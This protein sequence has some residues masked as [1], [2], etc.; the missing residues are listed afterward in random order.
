MASMPPRL[1]RHGFGWLVL[2]V[3]M[4]GL[5]S[6]ADAQSAK[7]LTPN[8]EKVRFRLADRNLQIELVTSE[9]YL[10]SPI[11]VA[12]NEDGRM[13]V[14][15]ITDYPNGRPSGRVV[16]FDD[17]GGDGTYDRFTVFAE[18]LS[19]PTSVLPY[20]DGVLVMTSREIVY[21][22]DADND[23]IS[24]KREVILTGLEGGHPLLRAGS[25]QW[26]LDNWIYASHGGRGELRRPQDP[27]S[28]AVSVEGRDFRFLPDGSRVEVLTG[29][30]PAGLAMNPYGARFPSSNAAPIQ[31]VVLEE[32]YFTRNP[33]LPST[34]SVIEIL[35]GQDSTRLAFAGS[36]HERE[37]LRAVRGIHFYRG[38]DLPNRYLNNLF[39]AE[40]RLNLIHRR[41]VEQQGGTF[42]A[43]RVDEEAEFLTSLD[44]WFR[45]VSIESGPD[46]ALYIVDFYRDGY[47][48]PELEGTRARS[49]PEFSRG[50]D[51]GRLWRVRPVDRVGAS[52]PRITM[53]PRLSDATNVELTRLLGHENGW[54]RETAQRLLVERNAQ[55]AVPA[56]RSIFT[57][58]RS[59][60]ARLHALWTLEGLGALDDRTLITALS[61]VYPGLRSSALR[62]AEPRLAK[63]PE[64]RTAVLRTVVDRD[65]RV[66]LE[67]AATL[68]ELSGDDVTTVLLVIANENAGDPWVRRTLFGAIARDPAGF[69]DKLLT[70]SPQLM[71]APTVDQFQI[72]QQAAQLIGGRNQPAE[73]TKTLKRIA[74]S[75]NGPL[76]R[77]QRALLT[78]LADGLAQADRPLRTLRS[79]LG[80]LGANV[81]HVDKLFA[82]ARE[83]AAAPAADIEQRLA[84]I[85]LLAEDI[86]AQSGAT[87]MALATSPQS[88]AVQM[89]AVRAIITAGD[90]QQIESLL[91]DWSRLSTAARR[92]AVANL[93]SE[94]G[95]RD[96]LVA[97]LES[98]RIPTS[99]VEPGAVDALRQLPDPAERSRVTKL[100]APSESV[101]RKALAEK[102]QRE[103]ASIVSPAADAGQ[104]PEG[105]ST[106]SD[107]R[108]A[109]LFS[110]HCLACH[111]IAGHGSAFGLD[112]AL[113]SSLPRETL[114]SKILDPSRDLL[115]SQ[116][117]AVVVT[118]AGRVLYGSV[119][120]ESSQAVTLRRP[121]GEELTLPRSL[122]ATLH[123]TGR[124]LMPEGFEAILTPADVADL[125][126]F[127]QQP[128]LELLPG[129]V[130]VMVE[131]PGFKPIEQR[132]APDLAPLLPPPPAAP[133]TP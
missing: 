70:Y 35:D 71:T 81:A 13:F 76:L 72:L 95:A 87:L 92:A 123:K 23:G 77:G 101:D 8:E 24:E 9:P 66:R 73:L 129:A 96:L 49:K 54:W 91:A 131:E 38:D 80:G 105:S 65:P 85:R 93:L 108:G 97:A 110:Q 63:S 37:Q 41:R 128:Q 57:E 104:E 48:F 18:N 116:S 120:H 2:A 6:L 25:L 62:L 78:G 51:R 19:L 10:T 75:G 84:A 90:R 113:A 46:G 94:P 31:H 103:L 55:D 114:V 43:R 11:D 89:A 50:I 58:Q 15:E 34:P 133:F 42:V 86:P 107:V 67:L 126:A 122:I 28:K 22:I 115:S 5:T 17:I 99:D 125:L 36:S 16:A 44:P 68:G 88:P 12:W 27:A 40:P 118:T 26:G 132:K 56:L 69:L 102:Y 82:A 111:T 61:D 60:K 121:D 14:C 39:L 20:R 83:T 98:Q 45:P 29:S 1:S 124:S 33:Q 32:R 119:T 21:L 53:Y 7:P 100:L 117:G 64:L 30:S 47:E 127:L 59:V 109:E 74:P 112:L 52:R 3:S 79:E 106:V 130:H 4:V